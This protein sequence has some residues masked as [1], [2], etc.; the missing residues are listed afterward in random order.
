M[1]LQD[2]IEAMKA[3]SIPTKARRKVK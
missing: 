1:E 3:V 2:K